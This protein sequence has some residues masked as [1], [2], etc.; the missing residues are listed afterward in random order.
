MCVNRAAKATSFQVTKL[1]VLSVRMVLT[2][3]KPIKF[4][5][6]RIVG[7]GITLRATNPP[8]RPVPLVNTA[9]NK[10]CRLVCPT[11][12][13][14]ITLSM[15]EQVVTHVRMVLTPTKPTNFFAKRTA[16]T[17]ITLQATNPPARLVP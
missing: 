3:T 4:F 1:L 14:D 11:V 9:T 6:K 12:E 8:A 17:G 10:M 13:K 2:R 15:T 5:A 7:T 16:G